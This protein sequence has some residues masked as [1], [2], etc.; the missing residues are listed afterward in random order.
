MADEPEQTKLE[1]CGDC[2]CN[3]ISKFCSLTVV[4]SMFVG[5]IV[6]IVGVFKL[7][8]AWGSLERTVIAH[9]LG[10]FLSLITL[11]G[12]FYLFLKGQKQIHFMTFL[13]MLLVVSFMLVSHSIGLASPNVVDCGGN[14]SYLAQGF[15]D[16]TNNVANGV[17][18]ITLNR[19]NVQNLPGAVGGVLIN[20]GPPRGEYDQSL[21]GCYEQAI[22]L[23]GAIVVGFFQLAA[24]F[25]VQRVLLRRIRA[26]TYGER[27]T[28]MGIK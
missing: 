1:Q 28:E 4:V 24:V 21:L 26:K 2:L 6:Y 17:T 25:D 10:M 23:G 9:F 20:G 8:A 22:V 11:L 7:A 19:T 13:T 3:A 16:V 27:F 18:N 5:E 12:Y 15:K 14:F